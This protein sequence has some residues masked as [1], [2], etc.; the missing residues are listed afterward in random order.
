M[1]VS[2]KAFELR[3][4]KAVGG[5]RRGAQFVDREGGLDDIVHDHW[6]IECKLLTRVTYGSLVAAVRQSERNCR[7]GQCPVAIVKKKSARDED[8]LVCMSFREWQKW[9]GE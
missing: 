8:A 9:Y 7:D 1:S 6:S 4:A 5:Q 3:V 2:W